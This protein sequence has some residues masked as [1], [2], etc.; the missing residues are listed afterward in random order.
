VLSHGSEEVQLDV[1]GLPSGLVTESKRINTMQQPQW[2]SIHGKVFAGNAILHSSDSG[3][4]REAFPD[5][6][7]VLVPGSAQSVSSEQPLLRFGQQLLAIKGSEVL[8]LH[9]R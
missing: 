6:V 7:P 5:L 2:D 8:L 1:V 4:L 3:L 9:K